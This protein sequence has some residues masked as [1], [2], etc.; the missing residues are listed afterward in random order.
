MLNQLITN[1]QYATA[2]ARIHYYRVPE[3]LPRRCD[4]DNHGLYLRALGAYAKHH[5]N[6]EQG[7]AV[8]QDYTDAFLGLGGRDV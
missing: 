5:Y 6:T 4:F 8:A 1:L 7:K 2:M 3:S